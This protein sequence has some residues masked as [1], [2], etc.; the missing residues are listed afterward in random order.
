MRVR[1]LLSYFFSQVST[2]VAGCVAVSEGR[3]A[4]S[5]RCGVGCGVG[6]VAGFAVRVRRSSCYCFR[7]RT[8]VAVSEGCVAMSRRVV[9][10]V[11]QGVLYCQNSLLQCRRACSRVCCSVKR[12]CCSVTCCIAD[13]FSKWRL[14]E[15]ILLTGTTCVY[16]YVHMCCCRVCCSEDQ[17]LFEIILLTGRA[18]IEMCV[19]VS[20]GCGAVSRRVVQRVL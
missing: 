10:R 1:R 11:L 12:V 19:A 3:V 13:V 4:V 20:K 15:M 9:Q 16:I 2:C 8:C 14:L 5:C 6:C 7:G 18:C 17:K